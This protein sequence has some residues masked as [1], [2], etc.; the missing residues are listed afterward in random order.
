LSV[1]ATDVVALAIEHTKAQLFRS[2][3]FSQWWRLALVGFLA[4]ELGSSSS[5][6]FNIPTNTR[7]EQSHFLGAAWPPS[8]HHPG[9]QTVA[10]VGVCLALALV[11]VVVSVYIGSVMRFILFDSVI[12]KEC[13][14][15]R[16]WRR[17]RSEGASL[18]RWQISY[19][20]ISLVATFL[21]IGAPVAYAWAHGWF[22]HA[23]DHVARLVLG[24][25]ALLLVFFVLFAVITVISVLTKDFVVPQMALEGLTAVEG[26]RRLL[27]WMRA[28]KGHFAGYVG[29]KI[30]LDLAA[31]F[32]VA[33]VQI[34][35]LLVM[36]IPAGAIALVIYYE[37]KAAAWTWNPP[38]I[39]LAVI[40]GAIALL[41]IFSTL[42]LIATPVAVFFP[43]YSIYFF[44]PRYPL[45][46][47]LLRP[48]PPSPAGSG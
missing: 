43:A 36:L 12:A 35:A 41:L 5:F 38:A 32:L 37:A 40:L 3:R 13:H 15:R 9:A 16:G 27:N 7:H 31:V 1:A 30:V 8:L 48:Q 26:W 17:R 34:L 20:A 11:L 10:F 14:I 23:R 19:L 47:A 45:L 33:I 39:A 42:V 21:V 24:G 46:A 6:N 28:E 4:G 2:F 18:F 29:L 22:S 25:I 44:A